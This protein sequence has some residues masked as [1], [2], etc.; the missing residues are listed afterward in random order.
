M[1]STTPPWADV[2]ASIPHNVHSE[3]SEIAFPGGVRAENIKGVWER[4]PDG[5]WGKFNPNPNY[6]P[7]VSPAEPRVQ[8]SGMLP[9]GWT[10]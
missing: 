2:N 5:A 10:L 8:P 3:E 6:R 9:P 4:M 1:S 7:P